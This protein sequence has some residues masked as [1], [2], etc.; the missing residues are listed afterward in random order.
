MEK[1][2]IV[3]DI[4]RQR[5]KYER[6]AKKAIGSCQIFMADNSKDALE[7]IQS[8]PDISVVILDINFSTLPEYK[9]ISSDPHRE[10]YIISHQ[11]RKINPDLQIVLTTCLDE[12]DEP[13]AIRLDDT[14][15]DYQ[16]GHSTKARRKDRNHQ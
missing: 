6:I 2:L 10:G 14:P 3:D 12:L 16:R 13:F 9:I 7:I 5:L 15:S 1:I 8:E 11:L 4:K